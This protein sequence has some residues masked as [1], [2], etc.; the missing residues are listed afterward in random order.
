[1]TSISPRNGEEVKRIKLIPTAIYD[2]II[3]QEFWDRHPELL[4]EKRK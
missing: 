3:G 4:A 2:D 1:V